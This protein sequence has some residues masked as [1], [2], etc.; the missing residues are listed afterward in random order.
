LGKAGRSSRNRPVS[1]PIAPRRHPA[2]DFPAGQA[3][4]VLGVALLWRGLYWHLYSQTPFFHQ[5][6]VDAS[7]FQIW[8]QNIVAGHNFQP[9]IF[10]KPPL[11]AYV[12]A[13]IIKFLGPGLGTVYT[14]QV[15]V[16]AASSLLVLMIGRL[17]FS[18]RVAFVGALVCALLPVLPFLELQLLA[19]TLT[20]FLSLLALWLL[21][22]GTLRPESPSLLLLTLAG[23]ALGVAALGR[24]NLLLLILL[25]PVWLFWQGRGAAAASGRAG[26]LRP[27]GIFLLGAIVTVAPVTLRNWRAGGAFVPICA[28]FGAN[29]WTGHHAGADGTSAVPVGVLWDDLKLRCEQAGAGSAV[30][31]SRFL[32]R[33]AVAQMLAAPGRTLALWLKKTVVLFSAQEVRNNIGA[34]F[35]AAEKGVFVLRRWWPGFWLVMP[36]ALVGL[37]QVRRWG[38]RG[39]LLVLYLSALALSILPFFVNARFRAPMLPILA[40]LAA[41]GALQII[42][43]WRR[44]RHGRGKTALAVTLG[45]AAA[46]ILVNVDWYGLANSASQ[47][48]DHFNLAGILAKGYDHVVPNARAAERQYQLAMRADP[49]APDYPERYGQLLLSLAAPFAQRAEMLRERREWG[50]AAA[51]SDSAAGYLRRALP[52]HER[53]IALCER[54]FRSHANLGTC[55]LWLG[56][57]HLSGMQLALARADTAAVAAEA[58]QALALYADAGRAYQDALAIWPAFPEARSNLQLCV[59]RVFALPPLSARIRE[60]QRDLRRG[61]GVDNRKN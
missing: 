59:Q 9:D 56:D 28:N 58:E 5:P 11:Y 40:L 45:F 32:A 3:G 39:W 13:G 23:L 15:L 54:S 25:V 31:S 36:L 27:V 22:R 35:L 24:P 14:L 61:P 53:A 29:L 48:R 42:D 33:E 41:A 30:A 34:P 37:G 49:S 57:G 46:F 16:G 1:P 38:V 2:V 10:F 50:S 7:F 18:P 52:L 8:A 26:W 60:Y 17:V 4:I 6:V 20:T 44:F 51:F 21:L 55:R 43:A 12:L 19:E 47:A